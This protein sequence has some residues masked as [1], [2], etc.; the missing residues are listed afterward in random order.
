MLGHKEIQHIKLLFLNS[1]YYI[2]FEDTYIVNTGLT[3]GNIVIII[4]SLMIKSNV[5]YILFPGFKF[6]YLQE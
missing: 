1:T 3:V 6:F 4:I 5:D 2:F